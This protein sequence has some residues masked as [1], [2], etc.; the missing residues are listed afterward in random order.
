MP[1]TSSQQRRVLQQVAR[2]ARKTSLGRGMFGRLGRRFGAFGELLGMVVDILSGGADVPSRRDIADAVDLLTKQGFRVEPGPEPPRVGGE[3]PVQTGVQRP[4]KPER[5]QRPVVST[6]T[7]GGVPI[8]EP[9]EAAELWPEEELIQTLPTRVR[10][11]HDLVPAGVE[12]LSPEIETPESSNVF[13]LQYDYENRILYV[14]FK[15]EGPAVDYKESVSVC[16]GKRYKCA[17]RAHQPG[18]LYSYGGAGR[19]VAPEKFA[20]FV[21]S[22]SKGAWIW[23][24]LRVCG[25]Q[26]QHRVPYTLVTVAGDYV[27]RKATRRGYRTR[28]VPTVGLGRRGAR[29]STLPERIR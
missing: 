16:T 7:R 13:S 8:V 9:A 29:L 27:P 22:A 20:E 15:A 5:T 21:G 17:V 6:R 25:S 18:P 28:T 14:R 11:A 10:G 1:L 3:P 19:G 23:Q 4:V 12:G 2:Y 26:W 24:N